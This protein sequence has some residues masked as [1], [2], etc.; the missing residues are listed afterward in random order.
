LVAVNVSSGL[1]AADKFLPLSKRYPRKATVACSKLSRQAFLTIIKVN[2][3]PR[4]PESATLGGGTQ[5]IACLI[6]LATRSRTEEA[7][8]KHHRTALTVAL[9]VGLANGLIIH[10]AR[11]QT[12]PQTQQ[13]IDSLQRQIN[14][15][16]Q[17][18]AHPA[19]APAPAPAAVPAGGHEFL[20][21]KAGP[22]VTF[23]TRGGEASI[24]GNLDVSF[25]VATKG[26]NRMQGAGGPADVP[27]GNGGWMPD[28]SSNLSYIGVRGFQTLGSD[29]FNFV[30]QLETQV[31]L[32]VT[33]GTPQTNSNQG[34]R[35]ASAL[36][37]RNSFIGISG[38]AWGA[39]K[40]GKT[41]A[42]Y[43]TSTARMNPFVGMPGDYSVI[44]G[45]SGGD[46]RV[47][48][49][50]RFSHAVWYES[51]AWRGLRF[52]A[53]LSPG[54][55]RAED[56][57]NIPS[58]EPE[59]AGGNSP[60]S[61]AL[62]G[63]CN[64]GSFSDA[65]SASLSW[66]GAGLY[67]TGG[68]EMHRKVNRTSDLFTLTSNPNAT[69]GLNGFDPNDVADERAW[70]IGAQYKFRTGTTVSGIWENMKRY[71]PGY[72][73]PQDERTRSGFWLALSQDMTSADSLH[74]GWAH[75]NK[76]KGD[77]GQHNPPQSATPDPFLGFGFRDADNRADML[78]FAYKH[79]VDRNLTWYMNYATTRNKPFAHYD[80]GAGGR[81]VTTDCHDATNTDT[82]GF[83]PHPNAPRC[84]TGGHLQA[85]SIGMNYRF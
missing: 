34:Q 43:K 85:I 24:Y 8:M 55:N 12:D 70:K 4:K 5:L 50:T 3:L 60:G 7:A 78:T 9:S 61:G 53:L 62:P 83:D 79:A 17:S 48:F 25:D 14:D 72:L 58:G 21:R 20:E 76:A 67:V 54:Q 59:C 51:P 71:V 33:P 69:P 6:C 38:P 82:L 46:N 42:P 68:Y 28:I 36:V 35:V 27:A 15:L 1:Q 44:M 11:A 63:A 13:K 22:G 64:D 39:L 65:Y 19:P 30:Y 41:D 74:F 57:S 80:L 73:E 31:D 52:A 45:N 49:G 29:A 56:S 23:F 2:R 26:I 77:I 84:W 47:E 37:S 18:V 75:A 16:K 66:E 81:S 40:I 10:Q 32:S